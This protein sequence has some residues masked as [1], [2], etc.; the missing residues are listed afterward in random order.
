MNPNSNSIKGYLMEIFT[1]QNLHSAFKSIKLSKG[2]LS[3]HLMVFMQLGQN[4]NPLN[5]D[6]HSRGNL[7]IQT[8]A[9]LPT[10]N[11]IMNSRAILK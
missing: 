11:P 8:L 6:K 9:K 1:L 2:I 10:H 3:Y 7:K 5:G 4:E